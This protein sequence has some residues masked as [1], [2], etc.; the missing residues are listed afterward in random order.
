MDDFVVRV[1]NKEEERIDE[2]DRL[3]REKRGEGGGE[4][5][6]GDML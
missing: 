6:M 3:G 5:K 1:P 2:G 4:R